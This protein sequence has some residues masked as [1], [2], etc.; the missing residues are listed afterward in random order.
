MGWRPQDFLHTI[1]RSDLYQINQSV[2]VFLQ[3]VSPSFD[4]N[5]QMNICIN[6]SEKGFLFLDNDSVQLSF[7][8]HTIGALK[9]PGRKKEPKKTHNQGTGRHHYQQHDDDSVQVLTL[10]ISAL[11]SA[12]KAGEKKEPKN[13]WWWLNPNFNSDNQ[14]TGKHWFLRQPPLSEPALEEVDKVG[15]LSLSFSSWILLIFN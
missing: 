8:T 1:M 10:T 4:S 15:K 5:T 9:K 7:G 13:S 12:K 6:H 2:K 11:F 14:G 3:W